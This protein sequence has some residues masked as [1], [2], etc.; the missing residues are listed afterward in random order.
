MDLVPSGP[1]S[2]KSR[3]MLGRGT[4]PISTICGAWELLCIFGVEELGKR[5]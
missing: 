4:E 1:K 3:Q 5:I 2:Q